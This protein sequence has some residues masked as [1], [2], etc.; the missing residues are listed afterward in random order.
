MDNLHGAPTPVDQGADM[1]REPELPKAVRLR[2]I[3]ALAKDA[4]RLASPQ[5][6]IPRKRVKV[7]EKQRH[8]NMVMGV[9][10]TGIL[11]LDYD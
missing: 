6:G 9:S 7:S 8:D 11:P 4:D 2:P 5:Q 1:A 3:I 10:A